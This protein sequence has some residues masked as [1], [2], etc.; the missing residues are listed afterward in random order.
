MYVKECEYCKK[1]IKTKFKLK[2]FCNAICQGKNYN[3]RPEVKEKNRIRTKKYRR[4]HPEWK[5]RHRILELTRHR[6]RRAKYWKEYGKRPEVRLKIREKEKLRRKTDL[7]YAITDRLKRS[8]HHA[9]T[10]YSKTGKIMSSK[11]YGI[12]WKEIIETLKP[13]PKYL[14]NFEIDHIKPLHTFNLTKTS[15]VKKAFAPS[16]LQW[17]TIDENRRKAGKIIKNIKD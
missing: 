1:K 10:K 12:D 2:R 6:E 5:E 7:N 9:M 15:E 11:K 8:L 4:I 14:K 3:S 17:L 16:N 13:F